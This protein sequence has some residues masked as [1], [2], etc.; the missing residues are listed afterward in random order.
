MMKRILFLT[1]MCVASM[2]AYAQHFDG[3]API[4]ELFGDKAPILANATVAV[5][6]GRTEKSLANNK[7]DY[8]KSVSVTDS[9]SMSKMNSVAMS[10]LEKSV[11]NELSS[12]SGIIN[13]AFYSFPPVARHNRY[14]FIFSN[15]KKTV[16]MY[17]EGDATFADIKKMI[18][19]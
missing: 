14:M 18:K 17:M 19:K 1:V 13:Y 8:F 3:L 10:M 15:G 16:A 5:V 12:S 11:D 4:S 6:S 9:A 7:L 2:C